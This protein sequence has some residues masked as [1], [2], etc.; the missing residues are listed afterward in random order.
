MGRSLYSINKTKFVRKQ[1][2]SG[3]WTL[4]HTTILLN[5][6]GSDL[7]EIANITVP[8]EEDK[9]KEGASEIRSREFVIW[10]QI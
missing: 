3:S 4:K 8:R 1:A 2:C 10:F 7:R 6:M 9:L 5:H